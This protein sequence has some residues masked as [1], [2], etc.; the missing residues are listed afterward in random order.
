MLMPACKPSSLADRK[1]MP[2]YILLAPASS[3]A[4]K[5]VA[6]LRYTPGQKIGAG[7]KGQIFCAVKQWE[8][9]RSCA[10]ECAVAGG[11]IR[12]GGCYNE[13]HPVQLR[14]GEG[15]RRHRPPEV[16]GVLGIPGA[17]RSVSHG[18]V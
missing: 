2:P 8:H 13:R 11:I 12:K 5:Q 15:N 3:A 1:C 16:I 10:A 14:F 7:C 6:K 17:N 9:G 4:S 18:D